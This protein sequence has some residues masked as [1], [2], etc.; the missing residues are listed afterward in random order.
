MTPFLLVCAGTL[1]FAGIT[2]IR[3]AH[4]FFT[5]V[6][7][8]LT[9]PALGL[10]AILAY[11]GQVRELGTLPLKH[12]F[13]QRSFHLTTLCCLV[14]SLMIQGPASFI[15][16]MALLSLLA[17]F[18]SFQFFPKRLAGF[19]EDYTLLTSLFGVMCIFFRAAFV[20]FGQSGSNTPEATAA[21]W[22]G[23][24]GT[25][26]LMV[27]GAVGVKG[28]WKFG[29][30]KLLRVDVFHYVLAIGNVCLVQLFEAMW[31]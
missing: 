3:P 18:L 16:S 27:A 10:V 23:I 12:P 28:I 21:A 6:S 8:F 4:E 20:I 30:I 11:T 9:M 25:V 5:E 2:A 31:Q 14:F 29:P 24:A 15:S 7:K 13:S 1:R 22:Y 26:L 17:G 19:K